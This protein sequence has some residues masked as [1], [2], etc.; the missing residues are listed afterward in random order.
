MPSAADI[1]RRG[2]A[3]LAM[4]ADVYVADDVHPA[5]NTIV[6]EIAPDEARMLRFLALSGPQPVVDIRTNR[7]LGIGSELVSGDLSSVAEYAGCRHLDRAAAYLTN[8][9]RLGLV[10]ISD[11]PTELSRYM[12]LEVQPHVE[13]ALK[14]AGRVPKIVRRACG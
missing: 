10:S 9:K 14:K 4:S 12:V 13:A 11:D 8:L 6:S 3:L 5:Y 7:P 1:R 2:D